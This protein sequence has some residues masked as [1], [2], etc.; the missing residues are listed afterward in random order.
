M[1]QSIVK[2]AL[3]IFLFSISKVT[4]AHNEDPKDPKKVSVLVNDLKPGY[5]TLTWVDIE[6]TSIQI[7]SSN[8]QFI[9]SIPVLDA[10]SLHLNGLIE[11]DYE[12]SFIRGNKVVATEK[13]TV[14]K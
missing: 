12:I 1:N 8:G 3:V 5:V 13:L 7:Y 9:P 10:T 14:S 11:G 6:I 4:F 2:I